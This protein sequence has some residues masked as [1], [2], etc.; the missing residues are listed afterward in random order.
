MALRARRDGGDD[1]RARVRDDGAA[2]ASADAGGLRRHDPRAVG[3]EKGGIVWLLGGFL[4]CFVVAFMLNAVATTRAPATAA[5]GSSVLGAAWIGLGL[6]QLILLR[7]LHDKGRLIAF[8]RAA[9]GVRGRHVRVLRRPALRQ[10]PDVAD[11]LAGEDLGGLR[12]RLGRRDLRLV[13]RALPGPA[14]LPQRSGRPSSSAASSC[15][16]R[17]RATSS[18]RC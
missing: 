3:A 18:S 16:P 11:A 4:S 14:S 9:H 2:A 5:V 8:T 17:R 12:R 13:R 1:R 6:G 15:S 7:E 10:A